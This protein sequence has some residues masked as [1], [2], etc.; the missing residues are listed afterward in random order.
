MEKKRN[1]RGDP[2][3]VDDE[4]DDGSLNVVR[5][6]AQRDGYVMVHAAE[7]RQLLAELDE[8]RDR[9]AALTHY[10]DRAEEQENRKW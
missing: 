6:V 10:R 4:D 5:A 1:M 8:L 9:V 7:L 3:R 2:G